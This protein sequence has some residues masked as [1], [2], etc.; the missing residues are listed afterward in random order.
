MIAF[1]LADAKRICGSGRSAVG[2]ALQVLEPL[3]SQVE[4]RAQLLLLG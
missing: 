3:Q 1:G 4:S 2:D